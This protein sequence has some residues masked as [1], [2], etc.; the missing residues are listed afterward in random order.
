MEKTS[1]PLYRYRGRVSSS[2]LPLFLDGKSVSRRKEH[3]YLGLVINCCLTWLPANAKVIGAGM[4]VL[5]ILWKLGWSDL[6]WDF[7]VSTSPVHRLTGGVLMSSR[8]T[9]C[10]PHTAVVQQRRH[11]TMHRGGHRLCIRKFAKNVAPLVEGERSP[12]QLQAN[13]R[14]LRIIGMLHGTSSASYLLRRYTD[15]LYGVTHGCLAANF[16]ERH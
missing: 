14:A 13:T 15:F 10:L 7:K 5:P 1:F 12:L 11:E 6:G 2:C 16:N 4:N 8:S 3:R 9:S